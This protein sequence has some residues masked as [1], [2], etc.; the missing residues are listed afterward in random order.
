MSLFSVPEGQL[1]ES[2]SGTVVLCQCQGPDAYQVVEV[3][4]ILSV[5]SMVPKQHD[6]ILTYFLGEKI[7]LDIAYLAGTAEGSNGRVEEEDE[8]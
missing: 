8:E 1:L 5:V 3:T 4:S 6:G 7:G 2:S